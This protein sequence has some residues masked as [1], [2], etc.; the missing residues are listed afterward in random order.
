MNNMNLVQ[1]ARMILEQL[2]FIQ[3]FHIILEQKF[4]GWTAFIPSNLLPHYFKAVLELNNMNLVHF[5][6]MILEQLI[7]QLNLIQFSH[8]I[9]EQ[10]FLRWTAFIWSNLGLHYFRAVI[11]MDNMNLVHLACIIL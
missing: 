9:L 10:K 6:R 3:F 1:F 5:A 7:R 8:I 11:E 4:F 2:N